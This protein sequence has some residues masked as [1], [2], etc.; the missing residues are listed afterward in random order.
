MLASGG[1]LLAEHLASLGNPSDDPQV[2]TLISRRYRSLMEAV[3]KLIITNCASTL[4]SQLQAMCETLDS[5]IRRLSL[6]RGGEGSHIV[7]S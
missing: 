7:L 6:K 1:P 2:E 3:E 4:Q 5:K